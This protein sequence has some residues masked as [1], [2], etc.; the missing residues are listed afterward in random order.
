MEMNTR[1]IRINKKLALA[2]SLTAVV[3]GLG[4]GVAFAGA[5]ESG[6]DNINPASTP[7]TASN[8]TNITFKG[9]INGVAITVTCTV[10]SL[11]GTTPASGLGPVNISNPT[12]GSSAAPCKDSAG[13]TDTVTTNSTNGPWQLTFCDEANDEGIV[14][15][16]TTDEPA[17]HPGHTGDA[18]CKTGDALQITIPKAGATFRSTALSGCTITA[19]PSGSANISGAYDDVNTL[20]FSSA[21]IPVSGSGCFASSSAISGSYKSS[22]NI[23]DV[24]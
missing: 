24:S 13:G 15:G 4:T 17:G 10:A 22:I 3:V 16:S 9:T 21:S 6:G 5:E 19:A 14:I 12:F 20:T 7:F 1:M 2:A 23:Q 8:S 11:S 18:S